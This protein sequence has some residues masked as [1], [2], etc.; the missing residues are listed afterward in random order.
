MNI[1]KMAGIALFFVSVLG[2]M[3]AVLLTSSNVSQENFPKYVSLNSNSLQSNTTT[4]GSKPVQKVNVVEPRVPVAQVGKA[5][6]DNSVS[7]TTSTESQAT[8]TSNGS[9]EVIPTTPTTETQNSGDSGSGGTTVGSS[10]NSGGNSGI[11]LNSGDSGISGNSPG[12]S[13]TP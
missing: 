13:S 2:S 5:P 12:A 11:W 9:S 3:T 4:P 10:G 6:E 1:L 7:T 8:T